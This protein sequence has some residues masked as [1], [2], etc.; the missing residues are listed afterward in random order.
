[1]IDPR[2]NIPQFLLPPLAADETEATRKN[3]FLHTTNGSIDVAIHVVGD[4]DS[5]Q[6]VEIALKSSNGG[7]ATRLVCSSILSVFTGSS[8]IASCSMHPQPHVHH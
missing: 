6:K 3:V 7:I 2:I 5:K 4:G 1:V 8:I